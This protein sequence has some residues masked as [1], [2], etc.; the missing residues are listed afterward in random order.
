[1]TVGTAAKSPSFATRKVNGLLVIASAY[2]TVDPGFES[3]SF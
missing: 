2:R 1:L 3:R